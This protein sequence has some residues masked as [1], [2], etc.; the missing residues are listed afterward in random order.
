M[1]I[2]RQYTLPNCNLILEG[3]STDGE[4]VNSPMSVLLNVECHLP[5]AS[6]T[7]LTG[8]REFLDSLVIAVSG[9]AQRLLSG[10]AKPL[11]SV[12]TR[13]L[14][15]VK[16]GEGAYHH[17][18]LRGDKAAPV[19]EGA[20]DS[21]A[22]APRDIKL[23]T[24]Q[25]FDLMEAVDQLLADSQTLP[26]LT[27]KLSPVSRRLVK[28]S[29]PV[30]KRAAPAVLGASALAAAAIALFFVPPPRFEPTRSSE[31]STE[32]L[33]AVPG[34]TN[35]PQAGPK[36]DTSSSLSNDADTNTADL[37]AAEAS[38]E[39]TETA[40]SSASF[41]GLE[42]APAIA[43]ATT[44]ENL[45][46]SVS[47]QLQESWE[48][49]QLPSEDWTYRIGVAENGDILGYKYQNQA[50]LDNVGSTPLREIAFTRTN[51]AVSVDEPIAVFTTRFTPDGEVVVEQPESTEG[52]Q[53]DDRT[54]ADDSSI[55]AEIAD[56]IDD[57]SQL[58]SLNRDLR[59]EIIANRSEETSAEELTYRVRLN[60]QGRVVAYEGVDQASQAAAAQTPLPG[61]LTESATASSQADFKVVF[62][63]NVV[64]VSPWHGWPQ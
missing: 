9:Y 16:P 13:P 63:Q 62:R 7:P 20:T 51:Q 59:R 10:V 19:S 42:A 54:E 60:S 5:G 52:S 61:L 45:R 17:L 48:P 56:P 43:D 53:S 26:D 64:E 30:A 29:E 27:L 33:N 1:T 44:L 34:E 41:E 49:D 18:I 23:S 8:G 24:V 57:R 39:P 35:N 11:A 15:E 31:E 46:Q 4:A 21:L 2:Q 14:V 38:A 36:E 32:E 28:P 58:E 3:L 6:A 50:A 25:F 47:S 40:D 12:E 22:G 55:T 37:N